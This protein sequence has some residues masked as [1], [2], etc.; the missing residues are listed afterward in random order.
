[1][2][3]LSCVPSFK[4]LLGLQQFKKFV[5]WWWLKPI[6]ML[7]LPAPASENNNFPIIN[8]SLGMLEAVMTPQTLYG[9]P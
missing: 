8:N 2:S 5:V 6:L 1:M 4:F 9:V 7:T 3:S